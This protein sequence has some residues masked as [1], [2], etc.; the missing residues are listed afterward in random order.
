M[1]VRATAVLLALSCATTQAEAAGGAPAR[2]PQRG[3]LIDAARMAL[4][5]DSERRLADWR[6]SRWS[7]GNAPESYDEGTSEGIRIRWRL[8]KVKLK[9]P[10]NFSLN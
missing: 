5:S 7:L 8:N 4:Q 3:G 1:W 9:A 2:A 6:A 10:I